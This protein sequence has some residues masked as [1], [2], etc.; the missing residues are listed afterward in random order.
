MSL[1]TIAS[2]KQDID[3]NINKQ[4][5]N[6]TRRKVLWRKRIQVKRIENDSELEVSK[7]SYL[8]CQ[9]RLLRKSRS[10]GSKIWEVW[11]TFFQIKVI[12]HSKVLRWEWAWLYKEQKEGQCDCNGGRVSRGRMLGNEFGEVGSSLVSCRLREGLLSVIGNIK[13]F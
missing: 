4:T 10:R 8:N 2:W 12:T 11:R 6:L 13:N 1:K 9:R 3:K 5:H 7:C